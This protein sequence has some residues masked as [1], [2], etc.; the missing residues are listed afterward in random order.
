MS[1]VRL[2]Y[3]VKHSVSPNPTDVFEAV[4]RDD[5]FSTS[6]EG[7]SFIKWMDN[8][9]VHLLMNLL[10]PI[11]THVVKRRQKLVTG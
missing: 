1:L 3:Y 7:I 4:K 10:S 9:A 6:F 5:M 11:P 8:K 2:T